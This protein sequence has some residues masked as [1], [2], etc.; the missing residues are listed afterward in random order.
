MSND[1]KPGKLA[2]TM[3][4]IKAAFWA[5]FHERG[6]VWF[7]YLS[8]EQS[9]QEATEGQWEDFKEALQNALAGTSR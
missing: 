3:E 7:D 5:T 1:F 9:C 6:E 4:E 2:F 8:D